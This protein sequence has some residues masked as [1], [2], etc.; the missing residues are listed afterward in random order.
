MKRIH[1]P[2]QR[3][4]PGSLIIEVSVAMGLTTM[5]ALVLMRASMLAIS[6]NQWAIM[7]TL[8]DAYLTRETALANRIP[9]ADVASDASSWPAQSSEGLVVN[10]QTVTLGRQA[11]GQ[12]VQG[13]LKRFRTA[14]AVEDSELS[15][16]MWRL[17]SIL[18]YN[19]GDEQYTKTRSILRV[20]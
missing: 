15:Q 18:V 17:H 7:Q 6:G 8:T 3:R 19:I 1:Q 12:V 13:V 20:Q 11:G 5:L 9:F 4:R 2:T 16:A 14:E 10:E